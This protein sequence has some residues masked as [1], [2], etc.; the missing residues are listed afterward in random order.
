[1]F[2]SQFALHAAFPSAPFWGIFTI[3]YANKNCFLGPTLTDK[4]LR[5]RAGQLSHCW[6]CFVLNNLYFFRP[7]HV[8]AS[9]FCA[10]GEGFFFRCCHFWT[11]L[12][13]GIAYSHPFQLKFN[14]SLFYTVKLLLKQLSVWPISVLFLLPIVQKKTILM[15][16]LKWYANSDCELAQVFNFRRG[17]LSG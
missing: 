12:N 17:F 10:A 5:L 14:I 1:M 8:L 6:I 15:W 11:A 13:Q 7:N 9:Q 2:H 4:Q 3:Y 16:N